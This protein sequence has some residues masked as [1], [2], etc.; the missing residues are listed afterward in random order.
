MGPTRQPC[1]CSACRART[2]RCVRRLR[3]CAS[4]MPHSRWPLCVAMICRG[5]GSLPTHAWGG[6]GTIKPRFH[7]TLHLSVGYCLACCSVP[8]QVTLQQCKDQLAAMEQKLS[9][10]QAEARD[11]AKQKQSLEHTVHQAKEDI[12][13]SVPGLLNEEQAPERWDQQG[14]E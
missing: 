2:R 9:R 8:V 5:T 14:Q 7:Y 6:P 3:T 13:V 10:A 11:L 4:R 12:K 1:C